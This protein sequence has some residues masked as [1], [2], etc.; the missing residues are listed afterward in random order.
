MLSMPWKLGFAA[1][2]CTLKTRWTSDYIVLTQEF[3]SHMLGVQRTSV[4]LSAHTLQKIGLIQYTRGKIKILNRGAIEEC[5]CEC[6]AVIREFID[7]TLPH[8]T[9]KSTPSAPD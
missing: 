4:S 3:L 7:K 2:Y 9:R 1:G 6:Y 8:Q 5:A